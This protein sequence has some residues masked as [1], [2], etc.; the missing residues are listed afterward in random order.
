MIQG[1]STPGVPYC[2]LGSTNAQ[3]L[4]SHDEQVRRWVAERFVRIVEAGESIF[5]MS[6]EELVQKG[7]RDVVRMFIKDEPHSDAKIAEGK[8]RLIAGVALVDQ[9]FE[10][11]ISGLQNSAEIA[12]WEQCPSKPGIGLDDDGLRSVAAQ[13][14]REETDTETDVSG[15]DWSV[16]QWELDDDAECR[17]ILARTEKKSLLDFLLR[18]Q[19]YCVG[20]SVLCLP[21][22]ELIA[23]EEGGVQLSGSYN[24]S[25]TNSRMRVLV[26]LNARL[27][28]ARENGNSL[29]GLV[30]NGR[31]YG[32]VRVIA[33]GDDSVEKGFEG[34]KEALESMGH[35]VKMVKRNESFVGTSFCSHKW[36]ESG[37]AEPET[38]VKTLF[39]FLSH[40]P[41]SPDYPVWYAQLAWVLRNHVNR[42]QYLGIALARAARANDDR[43]EQERK[44][45]SEQA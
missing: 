30:D 12:N 25:S 13:I 18:V 38:A 40:P 16:Q 27:Q 1:N 39:R 11:K 24:T 42:V 8:L 2:R 33:M 22:G 45:T 5:T 31:L 6:A 4:E 41:G 28:K 15:W 26:S 37:L 17:R 9:F 20:H 23:Q 21:T 35:K 3:V 19:A 43:T 29:P 32:R 14:Q 44:E 36:F 7:I 34:I 10:R